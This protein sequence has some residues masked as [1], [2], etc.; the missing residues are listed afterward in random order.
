MDA[1]MY[2]LIL[3]NRMIV[4]G[5]GNCWFVGDIG[6][7]AGRIREIGRIEGDA[8]TILDAASYQRSILVQL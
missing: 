2:D 8:N 7:K 6:I 3:R 4:D 5:A 1:W